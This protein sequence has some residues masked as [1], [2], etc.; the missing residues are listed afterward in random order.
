MKHRSRN[1]RGRRQPT[2]RAAAIGLAV[3]AGGIGLAAAA[4]HD[5]KL[6]PE[7]AVLRPSPL[8]G[9]RIAAAK[10]GICHSADYINMQPPG[11]T[12][13]QW[14]AEMVKMQ[15]AYGAPLDEDEIKQLGIY[16]AS[17]YGDGATAAATGTDAATGAEPAVPT[18]R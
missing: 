15:H 1:R 11:M 18:T 14:T 13:A 9:Y 16:F 2:G 6:P 12:L 17:T 8:S 3:L 5:I 4:G 10:C 7:T